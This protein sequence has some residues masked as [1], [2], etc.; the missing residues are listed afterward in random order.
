MLKNKSYIIVILFVMLKAQDK[1]KSTESLMF[2]YNAER[3]KINAVLDY[4]HKAVSPET[5]ECNLCKLTYD[6]Y[7]KIKEWNDFIGAISIPVKFKYRDE[8]DQLGLDSETELPILL[9]KDKKV[10]LSA[11]KIN[12]FGTLKELMDALSKKLDLQ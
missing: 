5:Y 11:K 1:G 2:I 9:Y 4:I 10:L 7:G 6:N 8:L 3:G 12:S